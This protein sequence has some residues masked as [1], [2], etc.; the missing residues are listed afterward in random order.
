[1]EVKEIVEQMQREWNEMKATLLGRATEEER[2]YGTRLGET[3]AKLDAIGGRLDVLEVKL[4]RPAAGTKEDKSA[5]KNAAKTVAFNKF[6]RQG[7]EVLNAE[8]RKLLVVADDTSGGFGAPD[9][10]DANIIKGIVLIS[11]VRDLVRI[12]TTGQRSVRIMKR[13]GTFAAART[14]DTATRTETTGLKYGLEEIPADEAYAMVDI[15]LQDLEDNAFDLE[16][17]LGGEFSEQFAVLEGKEFVNGTGKGQMEGIMVNAAIAQDTTG[18]ANN[19]TYSGFVDVS[20]NIKL[21]YLANARYLLNLKTLGKARQMVSGLG[22]LLWAP[23]AAGA[24]ATI[25]GFPY[26]IVPDL[27]DVASNKFPVAFG[28]FKRGYTLVDRV[29]QQTT[30]DGVTQMNVGAVRFW[31]RKRVGGQVVLAEAIRKLKVA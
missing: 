22:E 23:M 9:E 3:V 14:A 1:M 31:S 16:G 4:Q 17:E 13:T 26:T 29:A 30:R 24:P 7:H 28:D 5:P 20:H 8:E 25:L 11:P 18:D 6:L 15:S 12:R 2:K 27:D 10:F 21:G 19:L